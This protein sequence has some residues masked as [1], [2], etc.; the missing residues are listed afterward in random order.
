LSSGYLGGFGLTIGTV[1]GRI[2]GT[3]AARVAAEA[4]TTATTAIQEPGGIAGR[5]S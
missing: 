3:E 4:A 1:W 5:P 2:A